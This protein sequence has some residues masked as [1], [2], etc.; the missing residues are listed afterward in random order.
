M[1][2]VWVFHYDQ[3]FVVLIVQHTYVIWCMLHGIIWCLVVWQNIVILRSVW[4]WH[5]IDLAL[6]VV[7]LCIF[8]YICVLVY[9]VYHWF[10]WV[11]VILDCIYR[12]DFDICIWV[13][14]YCHWHYIITCELCHT[15]FIDSPYYIEYIGLIC[16]WFII[17]AILHTLAIPIFL[18]SLFSISASHFWYS[19]LI[20]IYTLCIHTL[21]VFIIFI[22]F[23]CHR[24]CV[25]FSVILLYSPFYHTY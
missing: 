10:I 22:I 1:H 6:P 5:C 20:H 24:I 25:Y 9:S 17:P 14:I 13:H 11:Y 12:C 7:Y 15:I 3:S 4:F 23:S 8:V 21:H 19:D 2:I 16:D 18:F